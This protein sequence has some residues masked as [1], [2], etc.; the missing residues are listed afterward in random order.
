MIGS[1]DLVWKERELWYKRRKLAAVVQDERYPNMYRVD[2]LDGRLS[3]MVNLT[4]A[5]DAAVGVGLSLLNPRRGER[6]SL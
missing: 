4:R 3:D 5:K 1:K 6:A 2:Y